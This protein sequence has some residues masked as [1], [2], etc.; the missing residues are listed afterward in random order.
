M[1]IISDG[2]YVTKCNIKS[3]Y[4]M[5]ENGTVLQLLNSAWIRMREQI[6]FK[7]MTKKLADCQST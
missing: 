3:F 4:A 7:I 6:I 1:I 5:V 2:N